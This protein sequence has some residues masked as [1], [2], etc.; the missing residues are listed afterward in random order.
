MYSEIKTMVKYCVGCGEQIHPKRIE[1]LPHTK[2][3]VKCSET[4]RKKGISVQIGEGDHSYT[5]VVIMEDNDY[6][7]YMSSEDK[8]RKKS[9]GKSKSEFIHFDSENTKFNNIKFDDSEE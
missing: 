2:T 3:C 9:T 8:M 1:I 7:N 4:G 6:R 5:D